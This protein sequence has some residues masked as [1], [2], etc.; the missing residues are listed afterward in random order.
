MSK[1]LG[2]TLFAVSLVMNLF[3]AYGAHTARREAAAL[4][5]PEGRLE[6]L[7]RS[8]DL[9]PEQ[10]AVFEQAWA[11]IAETEREVKAANRET[12]EA[13]WAELAKAEPERAKVLGLF[14]RSSGVLI[15][16]QRRRI[17]AM[18]DVLAALKPE[19]RRAYLNI[20]RSRSLD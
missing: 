6:A 18:M 13:F 15:A 12:A 10:R 1:R 16:V 9:S 8:L 2:W 5:S 4:R 20:A 19:Q 3:F 7:A 14:D 17:E 11:R